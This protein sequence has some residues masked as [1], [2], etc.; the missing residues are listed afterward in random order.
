MIN[1]T[2]NF[3]NVWIT[4]WHSLYRYDK[5]NEPFDIIQYVYQCYEKQ[6]ILEILRICLYINFKLYWLA[7]SF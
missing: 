4:A 2:E 6:L 3:G 7:V 5:L 1:M